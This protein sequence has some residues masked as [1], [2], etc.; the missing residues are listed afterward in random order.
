MCI[1]DRSHTRIFVSILSLDKIPPPSYRGDNVYHQPTHIRGCSIV[2][3]SHPLTEK[4]L[5]ILKLYSHPK[6]TYLRQRRSLNFLHYRCVF[7]FRFH[8][9]FEWV[10]VCQKSFVSTW[11]KVSTQLYLRSASLGMVPIL[12]RKSEKKISQFRVLA[13]YFSLSLIHISEPTRPY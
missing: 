5:L 9:N 1:R 4:N 3:F 10:T 11:W 13:I 7:K 8:C 6:L 12:D 2:T